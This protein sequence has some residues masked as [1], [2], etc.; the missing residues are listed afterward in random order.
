MS[1]ISK[2]QTLTIS[3]PTIAWRLP[4]TAKDRQLL[5]YQAVAYIATALGSRPEVN[6]GYSANLWRTERAT[7][8]LPINSTLANITIPFFAV[9][10]FE[11]INDPESTLNS[12]LLDIITRWDSGFLNYTSPDNPLSSSV[13]G[14]VALLP[15]TNNNNNSWDDVISDSAVAQRT[16]WEGARYVAITL[17]NVKRGGSCEGQTGQFFDHVPTEVKSYQPSTPSS[18]GSIPCI[19]FARVDI[20]AGAGD[21]TDCRIASPL[22]LRNQSEIS[23][24]PDYLTEPTLHVMQE[25]SSALKS[26][27]MTPASPHQQEEQRRMAKF[28]NDT[29]TQAYCG[30]WSALAAYDIGGGGGGAAV[31][32]ATNATTFAPDSQAVVDLGRVALWLMLNLFIAICCGIIALLQAMAGDRRVLVD[33]TLAALL[34]DTTAVV[35]SLRKIDLQPDEDEEDGETTGIRR[36]DVSNMSLLFADERSTRV[37]LR[38]DDEKERTHIHF[39]LVPVSKRARRRE[40]FTHIYE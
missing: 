36:R 3:T 34:M 17:G 16:T 33:A 23:L 18:T 13:G 14:Y 12:T 1:P 10:S 8:E 15:S 20:R 38:A 6:T 37:R 19:A 25:V 7:N 24:Q 29:L 32:L 22:V 4:D 11:W 31:T 35:E 26:M 39:K 2:N 30:T 5:V 40:R 27:N 9:D 21:C 28:I